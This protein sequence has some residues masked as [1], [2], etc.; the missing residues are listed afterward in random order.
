M[1]K[2]TKIIK[3]LCE[4]YGVSDKFI[5]ELKQRFNSNSDQIREHLATLKKFADEDSVDINI[6]VAQIAVR[7][8]MV[9]IAV[10]VD[11]LEHMLKAIMNGLPNLQAQRCIMDCESMKMHID[12]FVKYGPKEPD[13]EIPLSESEVKEVFDFER[14]QLEAENQVFEAEAAKDEKIQ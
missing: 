6:V 10:A 12:D 8:A 13:Q 5:P 4:E 14:A 3:Q 2:Q 11:N 1:S 9:D 7:D